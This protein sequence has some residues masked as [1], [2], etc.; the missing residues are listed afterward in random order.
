MEAASMLPAVWSV[1]IERKDDR[2]SAAGL[3]YRLLTTPSPRG[4]G[5]LQSHLLG[6]DGGLAWVLGPRRSKVGSLLFL[7]TTGCGVPIFLKTLY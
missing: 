5:T 4:G 1:G 6:K 7:L 2:Q 3:P